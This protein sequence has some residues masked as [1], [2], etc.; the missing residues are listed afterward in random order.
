[1]P[2]GQFGDLVV[3]MGVD[4]R[5][6]IEGV[7]RI[8]SSAKGMAT[9]IE[10]TASRA[11]SAFGR[12][13]G[14]LGFAAQDFTSVLA[15][16]GSN[17][18]GRAVMSTL[19]NVQVLGSAFGPW[20]LA[21]TS[22]GGALG[23]IL[24]PKLL[25]GGSAEEKFTESIKTNI[26]AL[27]AQIKKT[28]E[29]IDFREKLANLG[30][31]TPKGLETALRENDIGGEKIRNERDRVRE[32]FSATIIRA[33]NMGAI[34][35]LDP[36]GRGMFSRGLLNRDANFAVD[37]GIL[38]KE[39]VKG[40]TD[41]FERLKQ[42]NRSADL[43]GTRRGE[44]E[45]IRPKVQEN[46]ELE[47]NIR[48]QKEAERIREGTRN[49][50]EIA[51]DKLSNIAE[52]AVSGFLDPDSADRAANNA[53]RDFARSKGS[54]TS[55]AVSGGDFGSASGLSDVLRSIRQS[56]G[57]NDPQLDA[58]KA[59]KDSLDKIL[60]TLRAGLK[61]SPPITQEGI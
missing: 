46:R 4:D 44:L 56:Q 34:K 30:E 17:S 10:Q 61:L 33:M 38:G 16:G 50:L 28:N 21:I 40:I 45:A 12:S 55:L 47:E 14:Q 25:E 3:E 41:M 15:M 1:M 20:G 49:P 51:R 29:A 54:A 24:I 48:L 32:E 58:L 6:W 27:D 19:N 5:K 42:L 52:A 11:S 18:L 39:G 26:T 7:L 8:Q 43:F 9:N 31:G 60:A 35:N 13:I 37:E 23:S 53:I 57:A 59:N 22:V 2:T 36:A